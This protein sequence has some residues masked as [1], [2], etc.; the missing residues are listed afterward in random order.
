MPSQENRTHPLAAL[1]IGILGWLVPGS[2]HLLLRQWG[3]GLGVFC[4]VGALAGIAMAVRGRLFLLA[5]NDFFDLLGFAADC[6]M[7][8]FF[9]IAQKWSNGGPDVAH[10]AGDY[11]T[12]FFAAAGVLNVLAAV[13]AY[14]IARGQEEEDEGEEDD[15]GTPATQRTDHSDADPA[16]ELQLSPAGV[17]GV[18]PELQAEASSGESTAAKLEP[19][20]S[21]GTKHSTES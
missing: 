9:Y 12:R 7:G 14:R 21:D 8:I 5:T 11:G 13:D 18:P 2:G 17:P 20:A 6:G 10:A 3:R 19:P 1:L 15:A 16:S 4:T